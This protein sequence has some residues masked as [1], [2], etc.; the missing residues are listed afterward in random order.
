M[1]GAGAPVS[2]AIGSGDSTAGGTNG[3]T[4]G[5]TVLGSSGD[6]S[7]SGSGFDTT[8]GKL[9][10]DRGVVQQSDIE[11][12][13]RELAHRAQLSRPSTLQELLLERSLASPEQIHAARAETEIHR[14]SERIPGY[15]ILRK[16]GQGAMA[17]VYLARQKSLDRL[18]AIKVLPSGYTENPNFIARF[19]KEGRAA[20]SLSHNNIVAAYEIG[21]AH[22][23]HFFVM[24]Y[25]DG[26][27][28][29]DRIA[30]RK[31]IPE[32][33][34][35][36]IIRQVASALEH[37]HDRGFV[38]R[39]VKPRNIMMTR[40]GVA[41]LADLGLARAMGDRELA[42]SEAGRA[43]G[44]P[45]YISP[46]QIQGKVD[47]GPP[48]DIYGLGATFYHM[49]TGKVPYEAKSQSE[50]MQ[51]HLR[52]PLVP[53][54]HVNP[55]I[56]AGTALIIETMLAKDVRDRYRNARDLIK[57]IDLVLAGRD[58]EFAKPAVDIAAIATAVQA[59]AGE[60]LEVVRKDSDSPF[61]NPMV[62][63]LIALLSAS[64]IGNVVLIGLLLSR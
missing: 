7:R 64:V 42:E 44:T 59:T 35:L 6:S 45:F 25:V 26:D 5:G 31:R 10:V 18:V 48:A 58:P 54:D 1:P 3:G 34:A 43:Y 39:D 40:T 51:K 57:D 61:A 24:E 56:S 52:Q 14:A 2:G 50:V 16:L 17:Q 46:E 55:Q 38:H 41:K 29:Y 63:T 11:D 8:L 30:A 27:T 22:G 32:R 23:R 12:C 28:V 20:A 60:P 19:Q 21:V 49:V 47:I 53:P 37:A 15:Q 36:E 62:L 33:E 13:M 9:L 4:V